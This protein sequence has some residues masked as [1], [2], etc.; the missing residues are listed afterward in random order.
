MNSNQIFLRLPRNKYGD[1]LKILDQARRDRLRTHN[2]RLK[3][4]GL[5]EITDDEFKQIR[6]LPMPVVVKVSDYVDLF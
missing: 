5:Q 3:K 1:L 4:A 6:D 2:Y